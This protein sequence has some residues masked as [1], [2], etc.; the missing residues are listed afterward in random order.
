MRLTTL[1]LMLI[2][3]F[4]SGFVSG[5]EIDSIIFKPN[6]T[7]SLKFHNEPLGSICERISQITGYKI[8][9]DENWSEIPITANIKNDSVISA[10]NKV[11]KIYNHSLLINEKDKIISVFFL[12]DRNLI[13]S[14]PS[15]SLSNISDSISIDAYAE[16]YIKSLPVDVPKAIV[17]DSIDTYAR[18]Y[19]KHIERT[20]AVPM[21]YSNIDTY[22]DEYSKRISQS[23]GF[24][25]PIIASDINEYAKEYV[26]NQNIK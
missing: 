3:V 13:A 17:A 19:I 16:E 1:I 9:V 6:T 23:A 24:Q 15:G 18:E 8:Q 2:F 25:P 26:R 22:A 10:L 5:A 21:E 12:S 7:L 14:S 20:E 11:L 4:A